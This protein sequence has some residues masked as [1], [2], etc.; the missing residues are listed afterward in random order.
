MNTINYQGKRFRVK[1]FDGPLYR[2]NRS[3][4]L[5][6]LNPNIDPR[7]KIPNKNKGSNIYANAPIKYFA[8]GESE[9]K[10]YSKYGMPY[11]KTWRPTEQLTLIDIL[12]TPTR[13]ALA[14]II[15][16]ESLNKSFPIR[17]NMTIRISEENQKFY[18]DNVLL[19]ICQLGMADG[20]Y[21]DKIENNNNV[22]GFHSEVGLC[23]TAFKKIKLVN[24]RKN[25]VPP[26]GP[27]RKRRNKNRNNNTNMNRRT[28]KG[29]FSP[30]VARTL[31]PP[32]IFK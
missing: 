9:T 8:L 22:P 14:E 15:G 24:E 1:F 18:D 11:I 17:G 10:A 6:V 19:A 23:P 31:I 25:I 32:P 27:T 13:K 12:H 3:T 21:M 29:P 28:R 7:P 2:A 16:S 26:Q 4:S 30:S 20:Y 5:V